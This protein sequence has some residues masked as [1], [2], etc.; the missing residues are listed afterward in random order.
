MKVFWVYPTNM[1]D[2]HRFHP[3]VLFRVQAREEFVA[4]MAEKYPTAIYFYIEKEEA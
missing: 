1:P 3:T 4:K 2:A